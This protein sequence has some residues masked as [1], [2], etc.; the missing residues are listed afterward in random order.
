MVFGKHPESVEGSEEDAGEFE[1]GDAGA[2]G[3]E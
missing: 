2:V 3:S 1:E